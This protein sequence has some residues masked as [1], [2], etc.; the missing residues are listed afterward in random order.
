MNCKILTIGAFLTLAHLNC[1]A[2]IANPYP[3]AILRQG[4]VFLIPGQ[5]KMERL[6]RLG[7][8]KEICWLDQETI[9]FSRQMETGLPERKDWVGF[10]KI[11]DL[12]TV[13]KEGGPVSQFTAHHYARGPAPSPMFGRALFWRDASTTGTVYEIWE[14]IHPKR[15][16][17]PLGIRGITP[18]SS[19]DRKW[20]AASLG[21]DE[22]AG[23]GL[24]RYP[25]NDAYRKLRGPYHRP[26]FSPDNRMLTYLNYESGKSEIWGYDIPDGEPRRLLETPKGMKTIID[27]GWVEDG[28][29]YIIILEDM[30]SKKDAYF[31]EI[32][33]KSLMK[34]TETGDIEAA[35]SWH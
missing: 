7:D 31:W 3:V 10:N 27:F 2:R 26:R 33:K 1:E 35:T 25:T 18:D 28:S 30:Q 14:T 32:D 4:D 23:V 16:D 8:V 34:L 29:G 5:G 22:P 21:H 24:Y 11:W 19:P 6:T 15:R 13:K 12:F 20:T 17:R 9:C